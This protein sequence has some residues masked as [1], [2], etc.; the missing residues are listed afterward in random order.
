MS[1]VEQKPVCH[2]YN[3]DKVEEHFGHLKFWTLKHFITKVSESLD[4]SIFFVHPLHS[5]KLPVR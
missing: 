1:F 5:S 4:E 3:A 2:Q